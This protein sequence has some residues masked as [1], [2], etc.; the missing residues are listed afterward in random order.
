LVA[1]GG[2]ALLARPAVGGSYWATVF[3]GVVV[4][5]LGMAISVAP[6]TT[7]VMNAVT[8]G[9]SGIASGV[10]NATSRV[11][12]VIAIA[13]FGAILSAGFNSELDRRLSA[14]AITPQVREDINAQRASL[15]AART[16]DAAGQEAIRNA[17]VHGYRYVLSICVLLAAA[18][19]ISAAIFIT[20]TGQ[21][22]R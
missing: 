18:S 8:A 21:S 20:P 17:F 3:P 22:T 16:G 7:T 4:L 9:R 15:G 1:A 12:G 11:A 2:F 19:S 14:S 6:L 5:G 13:V 10:N